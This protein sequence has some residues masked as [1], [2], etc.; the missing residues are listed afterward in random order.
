MIGV[1]EG[2]S[3]MHC[4]CYGYI[5]FVVQF[6]MTP[7]ERETCKLH[8]IFILGLCDYKCVCVNTYCK[9]DSAV[10]PRLCS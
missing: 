10:P 3:L 1:C 4:T 8:R 5:K 2:G 9:S 7:C 6:I